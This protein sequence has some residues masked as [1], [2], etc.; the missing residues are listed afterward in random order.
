MSSSNSYAFTEQG[1]TMFFSVLRSEKAIEIN[2]KI[3]LIFIEMHRFIFN[4]LKH[5]S[6]FDKG[7]LKILDKLGLK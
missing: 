4:N 6:K 2:I 3:I 7:T 5:F 1:V